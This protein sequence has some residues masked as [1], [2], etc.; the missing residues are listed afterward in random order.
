MRVYTRADIE[1]AVN[2]SRA[3]TS[4]WDASRAGLSAGRDLR[5][6]HQ[7]YVRW[8]G[9]QSLRWAD[10]GRTSP[11]R[12][13]MTDIAPAHRAPFDLTG[14]T[15]V[16]TGASRGIGLGIALGLIRA[17]ANVVALQRGPFAPDL[18][19]RSCRG[20]PCCGSRSRRPG[21]PRVRGRPLTPLW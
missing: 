6:L 1:R 2:S 14:S 4:R 12:K 16:V 8:T 7:S 21:Q 11:A 10:Y 17:G 19:C 20:R 5:R 13:S 3:V 15:A 9:A 18:A